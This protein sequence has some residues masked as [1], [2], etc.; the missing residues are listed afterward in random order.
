MNLSVQYQ[1][2]LINALSLKEEICTQIL[3][4]PTNHLTN[5][6]K[7]NCFTVKSSELTEGTILCAQY[8]N[9]RTQYK[10]ISERI[11]KGSVERLEKIIKNILK[12]KQYH[13]TALKHLKTLWEGLNNG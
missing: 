3:N 2:A 10:E 11:R 6:V 7:P 1:Q 13:P 12:E 5:H 4:L 8:Y 9:Y